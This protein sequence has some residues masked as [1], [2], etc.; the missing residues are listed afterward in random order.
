MELLSIFILRIRPAFWFRDTVKIL[1][2]TV[3]NRKGNITWLNYSIPTKI[4]RVTTCTIIGTKILVRNKYIR[5]EAIPYC[6]SLTAPF[7]MMYLTL[8]PP[9]LILS[10]D[11]SDRC[12]LIFRDTAFRE[13]SVGKHWPTSQQVSS[14]DV[15]CPTKPCQFSPAVKSSLH[16]SETHK[17]VKNYIL[18]S[19][20]TVCKKQSIKRLR[21]LELLRS[22]YR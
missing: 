15:Y 11:F 17:F 10:L 3:L 8:S 20:S 18:L 1:C 9:C 7:F 22:E 5:V 19:H 14:F 12:D 4:T 16:R 21:S 2:S 13:S 6:N